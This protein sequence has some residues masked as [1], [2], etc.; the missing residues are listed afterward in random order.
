MTLRETL[1]G[2]REPKGDALV[3]RAIALPMETALSASREDRPRDGTAWLEAIVEAQKALE[4][5]RRVARAAAL[6]MAGIALAGS[7]AY[8]AWR[9][10]RGSSP[11]WD[12]WPC[13]PS[14]T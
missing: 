8:V 12:R 13:S 6:G 4:R 7:L 14:P 1:T 5:P 9:H 3:P 2:S 11:A 10:G